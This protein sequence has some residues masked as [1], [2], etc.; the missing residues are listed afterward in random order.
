MIVPS[1]KPQ[2]FGKTCQRCTQP[3]LDGI[4]GPTVHG[5]PVHKRQLNDFGPRRGKSSDGLVATRLVLMHIEKA[6]FKGYAILTTRR[7]KHPMLMLQKRALPFA[8]SF[9]GL[10]KR[11]YGTSII[12]VSP[13]DLQ[14]VDIEN[15]LISNPATKDSSAAL[16]RQQ[17]PSTLERHHC[18]TSPVH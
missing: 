18:L 1:Q 13:K 8:R 12:E 17:L 7:L 16:R 15:F 10:I 4:L 11:S 5:S 9:L 2:A 3:G 14:S 6:F